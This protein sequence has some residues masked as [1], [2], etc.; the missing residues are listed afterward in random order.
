M[1]TIKVQSSR[2]S[3]ISQAIQLVTVKDEKS[4]FELVP[5]KWNHIT[6]IFPMGSLHSL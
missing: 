1:A 5:L 2:H 3:Q 4:R 6:N